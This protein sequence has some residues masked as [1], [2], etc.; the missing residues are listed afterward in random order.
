MNAALKP[1]FAA[2][3]AFMGKKHGLLINN[4]WVEPRAGGRIEVLNPATGTVL[5]HAA[6]GGA[7]DI[8]LAVRAARNAFENGPWPSM[9]PIARARLLW[10]LAELIEQAADEI[11]QVLSLDN[12]MPFGMAKF[13]G[14]L[15]TANGMRY[16]AGWSGKVHGEVPELS[17]PN[18]LAYTLHEPVGVVGCITPWNFPFAMEADKLAAVVASGCT[19]VLKPA[20]LTPFGAL[21]LGR[22]VLEAGI[23]PGVVNIVT[24]YGDPAGKALV[25][26]PDVDK[27]A[28][29]GS[30]ASGSCRPPPPPSSA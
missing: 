28:F 18:K 24:G 14:A 5:G 11:G 16:A 21:L 8:D 7:E 17:E 30:T 15:G 26:H 27:I 12:G 22:L 9:P 29:T 25:E 6:A 13:A 23:P 3:L 10:K 20:E 4:E 1:D 19:M 2:P